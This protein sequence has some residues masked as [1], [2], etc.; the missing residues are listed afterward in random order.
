MY[1]VLNNFMEGKKSRKFINVCS[2]NLSWEFSHNHY[3][4]SSVDYEW[5][6]YSIFFCAIFYFKDEFHSQSS[7]IIC[8]I[9]FSLVV[10][11]LSSSCQ[12]IGMFMGYIWGKLIFQFF[13]Q[14]IYSVPLGPQIPSSTKTVSFFFLNL[15]L[16]FLKET[17][18]YLF[19]LVN[20]SLLFLNINIIKEQIF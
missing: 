2:P 13:S 19:F 20:C 10:Y 16:Y 7:L 17:M 1:V 18:H 4:W 6:L 8:L 5:P 9:T 15:F 11:F 3:Y 12:K 14:L